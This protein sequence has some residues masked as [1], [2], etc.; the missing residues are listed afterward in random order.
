M[1]SG[2]GDLPAIEPSARAEWRQ[3]WPIVLTAAIGIAA[4]TVISYA[5][6]LFIQPMSEEF[7]WS[8]AQVMSG[9]AVSGIAS[10]IMAPFTGIVV[11]RIGPR[12]LGLVAI[13][14]LCMAVAMLSLSGG[15]I[16]GWRALWIPVAVAMVLGQPS[17]WTAAVASLYIKG[18]GFALAVTLCGSSISSIVYPPIAYYLIENY[19]W[20]MAWVGLAGFVALF[21]LPLLWF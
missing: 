18:R 5:T 7:G 14:L 17:V 19:G 2:F 9:A 12:R 4:T 8:R 3:N 15:N 11:D 10:V 6:S 21:A 16:W 13:S 1:A 20:R